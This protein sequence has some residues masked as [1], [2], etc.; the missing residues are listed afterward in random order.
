VEGI[1]LTHYRQQ[2]ILA[3]ELASEDELKLA[4]AETP[5]FRMGVDLCPNY[6]Q[7]D[8]STELRSTAKVKQVHMHSS[9]MRTESL[10]QPC[11]YSKEQLN[12]RTNHMRN[13]DRDV[14]RDLTSTLLRFHR[15]E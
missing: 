15:G 12:C 9:R 10:T 6:S 8:K 5:D 2:E 1:I 14:H 3:L 4:S 13:F 11:S 7:F